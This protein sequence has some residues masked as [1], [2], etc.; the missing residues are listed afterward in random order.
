MATIVMAF[1]AAS[2]AAGYFTIA[3][4][5]APRIRM[6]TANQRIVLVIRG[7]A[8]AFFIGCG[9]THVHILLHTVGLGG[10]TQPFETHEFVF[11]TV[12]AVGAWLFI[13][14]AILRFE[15]HV[16]PAQTREELEAA[17]V[18]QRNLADR[19]QNLASRDELTGMARRW[20]FDEELER[21]ILQTRRY[22]TP[23]A[24]ILIDV[25]GLKR[26]NDAGGHVAGDAALRHVADV[27]RRELRA[28]DIGARIGGDEFAVILP[29]VGIEAAE[30]A[31]QRFVAALRDTTAADTTR[32][33][34]SAGVAPIDASSSA[35]DVF[36]HA[37]VALYQAKRAGG[38]RHVVSDLSLTP[39]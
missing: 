5:V 36:N 1:L 27:M 39:T 28:T 37:D 32:T 26:I 16:V 6:P 3:L 25:D 30:A 13:A 8:I 2:V 35:A 11:H 22:G 4:V 15:L 31:A 19:A 38:D 20:R 24:L 17:I 9:A 23:S 18:E 14:G 33:S 21:Q 29:D 7:A 34:V 12:Q 10:A